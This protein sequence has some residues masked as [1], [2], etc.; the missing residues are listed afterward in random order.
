MVFIAW[1]VFP[2]LSFLFRG[3][4]RTVLVCSL[5]G[6]VAAA[7][8]RVITELGVF[9]VQGLDVRYGDR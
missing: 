4:F 6:A 8:F 3:W 7:I 5:Y 9:V 1:M 2:Q